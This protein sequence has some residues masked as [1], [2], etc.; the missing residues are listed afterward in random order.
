MVICEVCRGNDSLSDAK[1]GSRFVKAC[2]ICTALVGRQEGP[3]V[4][5]W[6]E[7]AQTIRHYVD[8]ASAE[9]TQSIFN[10]VKEA[11][12]DYPEACGIIVTLEEEMKRET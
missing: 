4:S 8:A 2:R 11:L 6:I 3:T 9:K 1:I 10:R 12:K 7:V 5:K